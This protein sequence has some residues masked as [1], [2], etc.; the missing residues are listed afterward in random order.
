[1]PVDNGGGVDLS[2]TWTDL[3]QGEY[4]FSVVALTGAGSGDAANLML[5]IVPNNGKFVKWWIIMN[6]K[7]FHCMNLAKFFP[8]AINLLLLRFGYWKCGYA[9]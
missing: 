6:Q 3:V 2:Y 7:V 1:M 8:R 5:S 9:M 4:D